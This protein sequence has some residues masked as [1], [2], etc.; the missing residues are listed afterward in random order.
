MQYRVLDRRESNA[1]NDVIG[2][3][4]DAGVRDYIMCVGFNCG[5]HCRNSELLTV[6]AA[7]WLGKRMSLVLRKHTLRCGRSM[8]EQ[9][10]QIPQK[11]CVCVGG[12]VR[13]ETEKLEKHR[14]NTKM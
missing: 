7:L 2:A 12:A 1:V 8:L 10:P 13:R 5:G 11:N 3:T 6:I 4:G 14:E 9:L